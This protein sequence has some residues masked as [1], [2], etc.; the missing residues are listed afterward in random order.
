MGRDFQHPVNIKTVVNSALYSSD[1]NLLDKT[2]LRTA[3]TYAQFWWPKSRWWSINTTPGNSVQRAA[4]NPEDGRNPN[5]LLPFLVEPGPTRSSRVTLSGLL[6]DDDD[7]V[8]NGSNFPGAKPFPP[9]F[10]L[11][12]HK[13]RHWARTWVPSVVVRPSGAVLRSTA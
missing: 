8:S 6:L 7:D 11:S 2:Y 10:V 5:N 3:W 12:C 1:V 4:L 9:G 13:R